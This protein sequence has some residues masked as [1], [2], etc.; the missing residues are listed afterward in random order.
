MITPKRKV[1][2]IEF[3]RVI[4][5]YVQENAWAPSVEDIIERTPIHSKATVVQRFNL[6]EEQGYIERLHGQPRAIRLTPK[7]SE[8]AMGDGR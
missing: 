1:S 7:G 6:L 5:N 8:M 2:D 4:R 3:L